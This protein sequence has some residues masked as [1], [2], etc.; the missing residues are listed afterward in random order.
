MV[1]SRNGVKQE[2]EMQEEE[3]VLE[4]EEQEQGRVWEGEQQKDK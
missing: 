2:Q 1:K 3:N 4:K